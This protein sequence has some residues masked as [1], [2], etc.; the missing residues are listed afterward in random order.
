MLHRFHLGTHH[1]RHIRLCD[2]CS[3]SSSKSD[4]CTMLGPMNHCCGFTPDHHTDK[5][6]LPSRIK[7]ASALP[8]VSSLFSVLHLDI[9]KIRF[10]SVVM[11]VSASMFFYLS[12]FVE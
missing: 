10:S 2:G 1:N 9:F 12:V 4:S 6:L 11:P 5:E 7:P 3:W 8:S